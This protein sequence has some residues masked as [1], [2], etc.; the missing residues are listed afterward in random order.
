MRKILKT[1]L[2]VG[3]MTGAAVIGFADAPKKPAAPAKGS[4][5][6]SGSDKAAGSGS[7]KGSGD[8]AGS[9]SAKKAEPAPKK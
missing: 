8:G 4:A 9:G 3:I 7:A 1:A 5:A 6:G 2:F